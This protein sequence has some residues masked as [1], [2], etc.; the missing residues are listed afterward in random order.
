V[1]DNGLGTL[2]L[3]LIIAG[4]DPGELAALTNVEAAR[5]LPAGF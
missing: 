2:E 4:G 3:A 1:S 5:D